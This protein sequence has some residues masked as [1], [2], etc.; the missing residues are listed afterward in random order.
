MFS[1]ESGERFSDENRKKGRVAGS[2]ERRQWQTK[3]L[4]SLFFAS[5]EYEV[6]EK[7]R[8]FWGLEGFG[9]EK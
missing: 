7:G 1:D 3:V 2:L 4:F 8:C 9:R 6:M 5:D